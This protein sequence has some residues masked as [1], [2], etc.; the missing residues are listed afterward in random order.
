MA[1]NLL[2]NNGV[3]AFILPPMSP[4]VRVALC[5]LPLTRKS[6]REI[7]ALLPEDDG[8]L[9]AWIEEA[10]ERADSDELVKLLYAAAIAGRKLPASLIADHGLELFQDG[11]RFGWLA[12][13]ME[14]D[15]TAALLTTSA[16]TT[17]ASV[18]ALS[19]YVAA[20]WWAQHRPGESFPGKLQAAAR[21]FRRYPEIT[22]DETGAMG[23][24]A[25]L[26]QDTA[27]AKIWGG[28]GGKADQ[29]RELNQKRIE[30][31][32]ES[33][34]EDA[35]PAEEA[36][37]YFG[38]QPMRRA[39]ERYGRN[40]KC[41]CGSGKKYKA[42]CLAEDRDR[43]GRSS[44]VAGK[45]WDELDDGSG[46][47]TDEQAQLMM[48]PE[49][50]KRAVA[51]MTEDA[52]PVALGRLARGE[53]FAEVVE[54]FRELGVP[55]RLREA[56]KLAVQFATRAWRRDVVMQLI[57]AGGEEA[58]R[59]DELECSVRLLV[60]SQDAGE[61]CA[62]VEKEA[63]ALLQAHNS[64]GLQDLVAGLTWSPYR[65][66]GIM[67]ARGALLL[68][69]PEHSAWIFD[70]IHFVRGDLDLPI[71][72]PV[73]DL[74]DERASRRRAGDENAGLDAAQVKLEAKAAEVRAVREKLAALQREIGLREKREQRVAVEQVRSVAAEPAE[75]GAMRG[76]VETLKALLKERGEERVSLR[77]EVEKL[78]ADL[79][80]LRAA[81][82]ASD[83]AE[84]ESEEPGEAMEVRGHQPLRLIEF[85]KKFRETLA[86]FPSQVG[87]AVMTLLG[88][89]AS[90]EP[91]A[92]MG[93]VKVY[94]CEDVV[95]ARVA[96]DYRLLLRFTTEALEV[97]DVVNRRDLKRRLK[98]LRAKGV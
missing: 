41:H 74:L 82:D 49:L 28:E 64:L 2:A 66:L 52:Q 88:R 4:E 27:L 60:A 76:K 10:F 79:A 92:F 84:E 48:L 7:G 75:L 15:V 69:E 97:L 54:A 98:A 94:E 29:I 14:G 95:R 22:G 25:A 5:T 9:L 26:M 57:E 62:A 53:H 72:D 77:R 96:G 42:C 68:T 18:T 13:H 87:R 33:P 61:F 24:L 6:L 50:S 39:V 90:G 51:Y 11:W 81:P 47:I 73:G 80:A 93:L 3:V 45:T 16:E 34:L 59:L 46:P 58:P 19:M 12:A 40:D 8:Q 30:S 35:I 63:L 20:R 70:E 67:V 32:L 1:V 23:A 65:A 89:L 43:M 38:S 55:A 36:R 91:A 17:T 44:A 37:G 56:W 78:H 86:N 21:N 31:F 71:D 83:P 85:P